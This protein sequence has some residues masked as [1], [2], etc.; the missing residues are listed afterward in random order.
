MTENRFNYTKSYYFF[1]LG[2]LK[3][4]TIFSIIF[5]VLGFPLINLLIAIEE[6][7]IDMEAEI[8]LPLLLLG[9]FCVLGTCAMSYITPILTYRHLYT[10]TNADN[11][12]SLPL[13]ANQRFFADTAA[14]YTSFALPY[15]LSCGLSLFGVLIGGP[16]SETQE[17]SKYAFMGFFLLI[18]F[19]ALNIGVITCCGRI[20]EAILYPIAI[21]AVM[22]LICALAIQMSY[23]DCVGLDIYS[24]DLFRNPAV[25]IWPFGNAIGLTYS[26]SAMFYIYAVVMTAVF[27]AAAYFGYTKRRAE[28]IGKSFVFRYS[29]IIASSLIAVALV[30]GYTLALNMEPARGNLGVVIPLAIILF[31]IMLIMEIINYKK[32]MSVIKFLLRYAAILCGGILACFLFSK[33]G[34][35]GAENYIP[36]ASKVDNIVIS[37]NLYSGNG[38][39]SVSRADVRSGEMIDLVRAEHENVLRTAKKSADSYNYDQH[40]FINYTLKTGEVISRDYNL[41]EAVEAFSPDFWQKLYSSTDYRISELNNI[42]GNEAIKEMGKATIQ[43]KNYHS[44]KVYIEYATSDIDGLTEALKKD[45]TADEQFGRHDEAPVGILRIGYKESDLLALNT[46]EITALAYSADGFYDVAAVTLYESY[47]NTL[48]LLKEQ[49]EVPTPEEMLNDSVKNS[50]VFMLYRTLKPQSSHPS[51]E[52]YNSQEASAVFITAEEFKELAAHHVKY[53]LPAKSDSEYNYHVIRGLWQDLNH[54]QRSKAGF[55]TGLNEI[56]ISYDYDE[57]EFLSDDALYNK[58]NYYE[59]DLHESMNEYCD[60]LFAERKQFGYY[61]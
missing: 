33:S 29:Y 28:N 16:H 13:T 21:N 32:I 8:L 3:V 36:A 10:K 31:I 40:V 5:A 17:I 60:S 59:T 34:G 46:G 23:T 12:L 53:N 47:E 38:T 48:S 6:S 24:D 27:L 2:R 18:M 26:D 56:G 39:H 15:L 54:Y 22:P 51:S 11:I 37:Y 49:G 50:E 45:L 30:F 14:A 61:N 55:I 1:Q 25:R 44:S 58:D 42:K 7:N 19:S 57:Y 43:L 41:P 52:I 20:V 35:F 9:I 4:C